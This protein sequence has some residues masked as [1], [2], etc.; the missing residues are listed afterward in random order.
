MRLVIFSALYGNELKMT[1]RQ[2]AENLKLLDDRL[3]REDED[4]WLSSRYAPAEARQKL[5]ALYAFNLEL[6]KVRTIVSEPGLG[7][8]RFQWWRDAIGEIAEKKVPRKHDVVL[9]VAE[10][11]LPEKTCLGL[12]DGHEAAFEQK[13][14]TLEPEGLLMRAGAG[15]LVPAHSWGEHIEKLAPAYANARLGDSKAIGPILPKVPALLRPAI[16]HAVL[17]HRYASGKRPG[18]LRKRFVIMGAMLSGKV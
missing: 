2:T 10:S 9:A 5:V 1:K 17:R 3:K 4:R 14:R 13:D 15:F 11:G 12:I 7:A 6:A 18:P 16:S 8:I